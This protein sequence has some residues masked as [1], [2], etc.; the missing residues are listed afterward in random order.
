MFGRMELQLF[1]T[2]ACTAPLQRGRK[3]N[4]TYLAAPWLHCSHS[5]EYVQTSTVTFAAVHIINLSRVFVSILFPTLWGLLTAVS[6]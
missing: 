3:S 2:L 4:F 6:R 1:I 5:A